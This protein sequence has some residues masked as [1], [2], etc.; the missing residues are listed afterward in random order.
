MVN[1]E[2]I[3]FDLD[4]TLWDYDRNSKIALDQLYD[5]FSLEGAGI[6]SK[7]LFFDVFHKANLTVWNLFD[8]NR[9]NRDEL[10]NKRMELVYEEFGLSL[11]PP[12]GFDEAY[13]SICSKGNHLIPGT[14]EILDWLQGKYRLHIITNGFEDAQHEK[15]R[16]SGIANYFETVTTSE[17]ADSKKPD[18]SYFEFSLNQAS[19]NKE[20]SLVIGDGLRTDVAGARQFGLPVIWF[21]PE[22]A[23]PPFEDLTFV[24]HL[25]EL[26]TIL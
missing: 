18:R 20:N 24:T 6:Q 2:H 12:D 8:E 7:S 21:N 19:A 17:R 4:H 25:T 23:L 5:L 9:M 15:L 13:Y 22:N 11:V 10:R 3:F 14:L 1:I 16:N 26:K